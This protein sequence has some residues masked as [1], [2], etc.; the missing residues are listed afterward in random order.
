MSLCVTC[1]QEGRAR[2]GTAGH[3]GRATDGTAS[4]PRPQMTRFGRVRPRSAAGP[5][6]LISA[7]AGRHFIDALVHGVVHYSLAKFP[8][9]QE[10]TAVFARKSTAP[11]YSEQD[12]PRDRPTQGYAGRCV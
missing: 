1:V 4:A 12:T 3:Q 6:R 2:W 5:G 7:A 8:L 11:L 9:R 10:I